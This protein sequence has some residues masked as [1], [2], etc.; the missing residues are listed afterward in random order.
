MLKPP[1]IWLLLQHLRLVR[2]GQFTAESGGQYQR[3]L[4]IRDAKLID[5]LNNTLVDGIN[6]VIDVSLWMAGA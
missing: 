5:E 2:G 1:K 6:K 4:Q 3:I